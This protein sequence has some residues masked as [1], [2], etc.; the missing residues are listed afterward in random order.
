MSITQ[1][2]KQII[3]EYLTSFKTY[4]QYYVILK[5]NKF[6]YVCNKCN[7]IYT[8]KHKTYCDECNEQMKIFSSKNVNIHIPKHKIQKHKKDFSNLK[9]NE[10]NISNNDLYQQVEHKFLNQEFYE[11]YKAMLV[12]YNENLKYFNYN[13][14]PNCGAVLS[15]PIKETRNCTECKKKIVKRTHY[16]TKQQFLL[17]NEEAEEFDILKKH[18]TYLR[19]YEEKLK[20]LNM[21]ESDLKDIINAFRKMPTSN[22]VKNLFWN[23][24]TSLSSECNST[25]TTLVPK[26][27]YL[28]MNDYEFYKK[29]FSALSLDIVCQLL[30]IEAMEFENKINL[31][32]SLVPQ[33]IYCEITYM[34]IRVKYSNVLDIE[35]CKKRIDLRYLEK[36]FKKYNVSL[37]EFYN[38][39]MNFAY[40][41]SYNVISKDEAFKILKQALIEQNIPYK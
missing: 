11:T 13:C 12:N 39:F 18:I 30:I 22:N 3:K 38:Y 23:I 2:K 36:Y 33:Y 32:H 4:I 7:M 41:Y 1:E 15:K 20:Y 25:I 35:D 17:T 8:I 6:V 21:Y 19:F 26:L 29:L 34:F 40:G 5:N 16:I 14:C 31:V 10:K 37:N 9:N 24:C 28:K 27:S